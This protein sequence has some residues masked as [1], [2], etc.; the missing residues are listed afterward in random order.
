MSELVVT[1]GAPGSGKST[2]AMSQPARVVSTDPLRAIVDDR[3]AIGEFFEWIF[4]EIRS[5]LA[6]GERVILDSCAVNERIRRQAIDAARACY[7][8]VV[9]V[10]FD[11]DVEQCEQAQINRDHPVPLDRVRD[12][13]A[14]AR[15]FTDV[16]LRAEGFDDVQRISRGAHR[17]AP[18]AAVTECRMPH[19]AAYAVAHGCCAE[20]QDIGARGT[21]HASLQSNNRRF[22]SARRWFMRH[23]PVCNMCR[24]EAASV[25]DHITPHRGDA[26]LFW[27]QHNWQ[28]LC[29]HCHGVKT[30]RE[31]WQR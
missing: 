31:S 18:H 7:A 22:Q 3:R 24:R 9:A 15:G 17:H 8:R 1:I 10:V 5:L 27:S 19:C 6:H 12:M 4:S 16:G 11:A 28:S 21:K 29:V 2:W 26:H 20:H 25:L 14:A 13:H 23:H 30:A